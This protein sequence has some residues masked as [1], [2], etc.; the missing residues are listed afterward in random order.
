MR[1]GMKTVCLSAL[2]VPLAVNGASFSGDMPADFAANPA[3]VNM[4]QE[5][6]VV[7]NSG[8]LEWI[9][10]KRDLTLW[11]SLSHDDK[12]PTP[13]PRKVMLDEPL[14]GDPARGRELALA[15][16]KGYCIVCHELPGEAW[17]GTVGAKI[18]SFKQ[19]KYPNE[20]VF[21]QIFDSRAFNPNSVMPPY[22]TFGIL[23]EQEIRDLVAY[24]QSLD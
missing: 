1:I 12:R 17:P 21:Q 24:L 23:N 11:P 10:F 5:P 7:V 3:A 2:L 8:R 16:D 13:K 20:L 4:T 22:G 19:H 15:R 14:N 9:P 18:L 6:K